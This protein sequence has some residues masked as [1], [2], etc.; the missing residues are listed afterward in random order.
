MRLK[1]VAILVFFVAAG[2]VRAQVLDSP[3]AAGTASS[4]PPNAASNTQ[5]EG[6]KDATSPAAPV[7]AT[8]DSADLSGKL[9]IIDDAATHPTDAMD[10]LYEHAV[11]YL[12]S[13]LS[14]LRSDA[15]AQQLAV[16]AAHL[17]GATGYMHAAEA[18]WQL[19]QLSQT[20][21]VQL[22]AADALAIVAKGNS[23]VV[24]KMNHWLA[25][26]NLLHLT[27]NAVDPASVDACVRALAAISDP[28]SFQV[29][30][31]TMEAEY[32]ART[33]NDA[34]NALHLVKGD[35]GKQLL[36]VVE[37]GR[38]SERAAALE[39]AMKEQSLAPGAKGAIA[40]AVLR[41]ALSAGGEGTPSVASS[42]L[43]FDA[44]KAL[45][46]LQW[47]P[48][49]A[50]I[51]DNFNR[52]VDEYSRKL[53]SARDVVVSVD[54]LAAMGTHEAAVRLSLYLG[55]MNTRAEKRRP[56]DQSIAIAVVKDLGA[57]GDNVAYDNLLAVQYLNYPEA[58]KAAARG[59]VSNLTVR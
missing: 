23:D 6:S 5:A 14:T 54:A 56:Y 17:I 42:R 48:A 57:L 9:A 39:M 58:I 46:S 43:R 24:N 35:L 10:P 41:E 3:G 32:G 25:G 26:Q 37:T 34:K 36:R 40:G 30:F 18:V 27:G 55:L 7:I 47:T 15:G 1:A 31:S 29:L 19:F 52:A 20:T 59:A 22:A 16:K 33:T 13:N 11:N 38:P 4:S 50:L 12:V 49:A 45:G 28:S 8:F 2:T 53:V 51:L 21:S 44:A